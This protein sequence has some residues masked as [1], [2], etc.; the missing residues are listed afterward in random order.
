MFTANLINYNA[1]KNTDGLNSV[2][3][4]I[5]MVCRRNIHMGMEW[6]VNQALVSRARC[7]MVTEQAQLDMI[8]LR[9]KLSHEADYR[10]YKK[11]LGL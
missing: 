8:I 7:S 3:H 11:S 1:F 9:D 2:Y 4:S 6:R 5:N 10:E